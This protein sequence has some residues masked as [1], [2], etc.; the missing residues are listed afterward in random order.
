MVLDLHSEDKH[1][2]PE[3]LKVFSQTVLGDYRV[4]VSVGKDFGSMEKLAWNQ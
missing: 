3:I 4:N 1:L 2:L